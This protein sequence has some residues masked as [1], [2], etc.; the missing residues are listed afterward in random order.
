M[1]TTIAVDEPSPGDSAATTSLTFDTVGFLAGDNLP[2]NLKHLPPPPGPTTTKGPV[3]MVGGTGVRANLFNPPTAK[4]LPQMLHE[5]GF[6][7]WILNWRS[8]IDLPAVKYTLDDAAV[9]DMPFAVKEVIKHT[10]ADAVKAVI[11]CQGSCAFMMAITA[12]LIPGVSVVVSNSAALH[13]IMPRPARIKLLL[14]VG[15]LRRMEVTLNG[16]VTL[17]EKWSGTVGFGA[18][19][20]KHRSPFRQRRSR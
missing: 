6:D 3:L 7:A 17:V 18:A 11:P 13:P 9:Q 8:S 16:T 12:G 5:N 4:T 2:L 1:P 14:A 10:G 15:L 19:A 20:M